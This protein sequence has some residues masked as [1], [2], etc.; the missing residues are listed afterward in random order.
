MR[1]NGWFSD[2]ANETNG[3]VGCFESIRN[4]EGVGRIATVV[5]VVAS[6]VVLML[7]PTHT[8]THTPTLTLT[9]RH[10]VAAGHVTRNHLMKNR[11]Q[12]GTLL[13]S[14]S[15]DRNGESLD[16]NGHMQ[17]KL[18]WM[19]EIPVA[20]PL[21]RRKWIAKVEEVTNFR[22]TLPQHFHQPF[23]YLIFYSDLF[24]FLIDPFLL[25]MGNN[26]VIQPESFHG[27]DWDP[28]GICCNW[29]IQNQPKWL[30]KKQEKN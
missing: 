12:N 26:G 10:A 28:F 27:I 2:G 5:L 24:L 19:I 21:R 25:P 8:H 18:T 14:F 1:R 29:V 30:N 6:L 22:A 13:T 7:K 17:M 16:V 23:A 20:T 11:Q 15:Y 4:A 9:H 3:R